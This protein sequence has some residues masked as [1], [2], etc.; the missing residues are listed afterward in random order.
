VMQAVDGGGR[1]RAGRPE[2]QPRRAT[3]PGWRCRST[4][5][6]STSGGQL[7]PAGRVARARRSVW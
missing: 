5:A 1:D 6:S 3:S 2:V 4:P 7:D